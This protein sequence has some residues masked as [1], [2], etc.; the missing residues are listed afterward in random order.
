MTLAAQ[1]DEARKSFTKKCSPSKRKGPVATPSDAPAHGNCYADAGGEVT[2][3]FGGAYKSWDLVHGRPR[4]RGHGPEF[5]HAWLEK[6]NQVHDPSSGTTIDRAAYYTMGKIDY[7]HNLVYTAAEA[8][9]F[10]LTHEHWG[11][12][13]GVDAVA[14]TTRAKQ[15]ATHYKPKRSKKATKP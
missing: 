1:L 4:L 2:Q 5:G 14:M 9:K 6:G 8:A 10:I 13:E 15:R 11:P 3:P 12:W 7:R